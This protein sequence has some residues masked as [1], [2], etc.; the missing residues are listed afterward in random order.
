LALTIAVNHSPLNPE[1]L[2]AIFFI[3]VSRLYI[4]AYSPLGSPDS[5]AMFNRKTPVGSGRV[6]LG[7]LSFS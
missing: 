7:L 2:R 1:T 5:A 4:V 6:Y 3:S